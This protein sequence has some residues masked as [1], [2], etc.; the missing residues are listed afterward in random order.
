MT[1]KTALIM[2]SNAD[3]QSCMITQLSATGLF[4]RIAPV[5]SAAALFNYLETNSADLVCWD[6]EKRQNGDSWIERLQANEQW[7]DLPLIA[8]AQ[9]QQSLLHGFHLGASDA[10]HYDIDP[11]ELSARIDKHLQRWQRLLE[12]RQS[13]EQLQRM[14][15]TDPLTKLGNRATFDLSMKQAVARTQRSGSPF[16]LLLIDLDHFK[17][18]NDTHGHQSGDYILQ[19]TAEVIAS[20]SR[21]TD[22]CCR[23]G[24]EEFAVI[25]QDTK[26]KNAE[27]LARRIHQR[28][29]QL[30]SQKHIPLTVSIGISSSNRYNQGQATAL[31]K[32]AD[33]AL[34]LAKQNG[35]NRTEIWKDDFFTASPTYRPAQPLTQL[36]FGT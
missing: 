32:E 31:I 6:V 33:Q 13:Q 10:V 26:G 14:A 2:A 20:A 22:I 7:N 5:Q 24:G 9:D 30:P 11:R 16:S 1:N 15:L 8:F 19:Q 28:I 27:H 29:A 25:L 34:Y 4:G 23:Y 35:R 12:L 21:D 36:A 18:I 17:M 3:S